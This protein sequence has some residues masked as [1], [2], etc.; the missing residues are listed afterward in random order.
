MGEGELAHDAPIKPPSP[1]PPRCVDRDLDGFG[2]HCEAGLDCDDSDPRVN[3][4][5]LEVCNG[6]DDDCDVA[7]DESDPHLG[8]DCDV[9]AGGCLW[10]GR[11]SCVGGTRTCRAGR[12]V[13][14][15]LH[16]HVAAMSVGWA[17]AWLAPEARDPDILQ[18]F[19]APLTD[20]GELGAAGLRLTR[21]VGR[22]AGPPVALPA[23]GRVEAI[24][25]GS[26]GRGSLELH[27][28][29]ARTDDQE[30]RSLAAL[31][32]APTF[33]DQWRPTVVGDAV[34]WWDGR[35]DPGGI[36]L[37]GLGDDGDGMTSAGGAARWPHLGGEGESGLRLTFVRSPGEVRT[38]V[39]DAAGAV[40]EAER[41][42][43]T[44]DGASRPAQAAGAWVWLRSDDAVR[45]RWQD[46]DPETI[47][48]FGAPD[49]DPAAVAVGG[50][51]LVAWTRDTFDGPQIVV[52]SP[53]AG[54]GARVIGPGAGPVAAVGSPGVAMVFDR[55][56]FAHFAAGV[57]D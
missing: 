17:M 10:A 40:V 49:L 13:T 42:V 34:A 26:P 44:D 7:V 54:E 25:L 22:S 27:L 4:D 53:A 11:F 30:P 31:D 12:Q 50:R 23:E 14:P 32:P 45:L 38:T 43:A 20:D 19:T 15:G 35:T 5:G 28:M 16:P 41:V 24:Y 48:P 47:D 21:D 3:P 39:L 37:V 6:I 55:G 57:C 9:E 46:G 51:P 1:D 2:D 36:R 18:I 29:H 56:G 8:A 52:W 33:P